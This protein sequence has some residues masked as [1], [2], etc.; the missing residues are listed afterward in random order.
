MKIGNS[1]MHRILIDNGSTAN[2]F[3]LNK[4]NRITLT[5]EYLRLVATPLYEFIRDSLMPRGKI[6]LPITIGEYQRMYIIVTEFLIVD[7][8]STYN[9]VIGCPT[10]KALKAITSIY[11]LTL[12]LPTPKGTRYIRGSQ[13]DSQEYYNQLVRM[14]L[15]RRRLP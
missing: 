9:T 6:S 7:C 4:Y 12:K 15:D 13:F 3:Y 2:I 8:R 5:Q 1:N 11:H 10:L 14:T